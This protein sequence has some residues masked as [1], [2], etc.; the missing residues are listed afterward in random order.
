MATLSV[1]ESECQQPDFVRETL[2]FSIQNSRMMT[3][4][5]L[6][7]IMIT[8]QED[9]S[10]RTASS[11]TAVAPPLAVFSDLAGRVRRRQSQ[12]VLHVRRFVLSPSPHFPPTSSPPSRTDILSFHLSAAR[13]NEDQAFLFVC[14]SQPPAGQ[15]VKDTSLR[16]SQGGRNAQVDFQDPASATMSLAQRLPFVRFGKVRD[17]ET[18]SVESCTWGSH[19][20]CRIKL[21]SPFSP[22]RPLQEIKYTASKTVALLGLSSDAVGCPDRLDFGAGHR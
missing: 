9:R 5:R 3:G 15:H 22:T 17:S 13:W 14:G 1:G 8:L 18:L 4:G 6:A 7:S 19:A 2:A 20:V 10:C 21:S 12:A 16:H 11:C